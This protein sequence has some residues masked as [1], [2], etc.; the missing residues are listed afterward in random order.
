MLCAC[1]DFDQC[2]LL[3]LEGTVTPRGPSRDD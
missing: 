1:P 3:C 2:L